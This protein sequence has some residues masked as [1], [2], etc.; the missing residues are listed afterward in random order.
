MAVI[1][2]HLV[3]HSTRRL[4]CDRIDRKHEIHYL[5]IDSIPFH[6]S[7]VHIMFRPVLRN[8]AILIARSIDPGMAMRCSEQSLHAVIH[9]EY[10]VRVWPCIRRIRVIGSVHSIS[11]VVCKPHHD[12]LVKVRN[13][14]SRT[15]RIEHPRL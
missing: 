3:G 12:A 13:P 11:D 7:S 10:P 4:S 8:L 5:S 6:R 15:E 1:V 2:R 9:R 14:G